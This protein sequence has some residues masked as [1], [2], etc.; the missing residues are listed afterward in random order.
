ML[1]RVT[2][3]EGG[4]ADGIRAAVEELREQIP[5]GPPPGVKAVGLT[6]LVDPDGGRA[7]WIGLFESEAELRESEPVLEQMSPPDGMGTRSSVA[8]YEVAADVRR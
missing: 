4:T 6:V 1:A 8:V 5:G 3:Y 2:T 7:Q